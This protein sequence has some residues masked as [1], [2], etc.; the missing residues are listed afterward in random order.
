MDH[1]DLWQV[2]VWSHEVP[3]EETLTLFKE[4]IDLRKRCDELLRS[5]E[6]Q[7][8]IL[9]ESAAGE[10]VE[11]DGLPDPGQQSA[12]VPSRT[13]EGSAVDPDDLPFE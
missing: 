4:G 5:A 6:G 2:H 11:V 10:P 3:L 9:M 8:K 12:A 1:V 7:L 13:N